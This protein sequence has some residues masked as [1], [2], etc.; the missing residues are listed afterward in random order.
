M[1]IGPQDDPIW[2]E[3]VEDPFKVIDPKPLERPAPAPVERPTPEKV[4][5]KVPA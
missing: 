1:E 4:P 5:E 3:P 2:V